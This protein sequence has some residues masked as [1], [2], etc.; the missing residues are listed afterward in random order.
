MESFSTV[1]TNGMKKVCDDS[2]QALVDRGFTRT[3][4]RLWVRLNPLT[5]E[6]VYFYRSGSSYGTPR[7]PS[8]KIR[9]MLAIGVLN[10][11]PSHGGIGIVSDAARRQTGYGYHHRFNAKTWSTYDRCLEELDLYV[12][13]VGEPWFADWRDPQKLLKHPELSSGAHEDLEAAISGRESP[14]TVAAT[15]KALGVKA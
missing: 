4:S 1:V 11:Q 13:E 7:T 3:K 9:V 10:A 12:D 6:S 5:A 14:E 2:S 8:V 15:L